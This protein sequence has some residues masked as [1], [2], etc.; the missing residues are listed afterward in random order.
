MAEGRDSEPEGYRNSETALGGA[1]AVEK[2]TWVGDAHGTEPGRGPDKHADVTAQVGA[3]RGA[4]PMAWVAAVI[5][6]GA[7]AI[8]ALGFIR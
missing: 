7:L 4:N 5:A 6:L 8:Y 1:D 3:G 2:T